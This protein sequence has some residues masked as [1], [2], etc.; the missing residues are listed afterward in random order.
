[1]SV[2]LCVA[3]NADLYDCVFR[4][5]QIE[6]S[7]TSEV[8]HTTGDPPPFYS[9]LLLLAPDGAAA[10]MRAARRLRTIRAQP[11]TFKDGFGVVDGESENLEL[12]FSASWIMRTCAPAGAHA[13]WPHV[14]TPEQLSAWEKAWSATSPTD[15]RVFPDAILNDP[16]VVVF[17]KM[18]AGGFE[19]GCAV[20][21]S[22]GCVGLSNVF[23]DAYGEAAMCAASCAGLKPVVGYERGADLDAAKEAGFETVG[24]FYVWTMS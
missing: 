5:H 8:W 11:V 14:S 19:S 17:G 24:S 22:N 23:G 18:G 3:N 7:R 15:V 1:M 4:A 9:N 6:R 21:Y 2:G 12:L 20:N 16:A 10:L 13:P